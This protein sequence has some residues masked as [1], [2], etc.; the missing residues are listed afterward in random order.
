MALEFHQEGLQHLLELMSARQTVPANYYIGLA[1]DASLDEDAAL[2]DVTEVAGT[3]YARIAVEASDV[4]FPTSQT[5]GT[6]DWET[7]TKQVTFTGGVGGWTGANTAFLCTVA[8]G[9]AGKLIAS[10]PLSSTRT[11]AEGDTEKVTITL[12]LAG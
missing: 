11:L 6:N 5:Q 7:V 3:G 4:G 12:Q 2:T 8:S 10:G 1:T 9:T